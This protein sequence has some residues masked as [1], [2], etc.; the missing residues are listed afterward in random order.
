LNARGGALRAGDLV[1]TGTCT[2]VL[3]AE[4]GDVALA[5]F[6]ALGRVEVAFG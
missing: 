6:G 3:P 2:A 4:R 5:D 1:T